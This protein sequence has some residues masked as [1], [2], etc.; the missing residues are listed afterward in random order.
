MGI[1]PEGRND[2][3]PPVPSEIRTYTM[4]KK[5]KEP[6]NENK[7]IMKTEVGMNCGTCLRNQICNKTKRD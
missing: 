5:M 1:Y 4:Q 7:Y 6:E 3:S 2:Y